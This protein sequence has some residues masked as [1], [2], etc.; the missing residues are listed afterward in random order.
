M[1]CKT[2]DF[3]QQ[4]L[5][6][7]WQKVTGSDHHDI[8]LL[9]AADL[10]SWNGKIAC[11]M[12]DAYCIDVTAGCGSITGSN[13]RSVLLGVYAFFTALGCCFHTP[14]P[15][16]EYLAIRLAVEC[17]VQ[18]TAIASLRHRGICIEGAVSVENVL[19]MIDWL[20]KNG[21]NSYFIQFRE[22]YTFFDHWYSH[23]G[24]T[25]LSPEPYDME[26]CRSFVARA[27]EEIQRRGLIYHKVGHGWTCECL[28]IPST[29]WYP[30]MDDTIPAATR[31]MLAEV[32]GHRK[33]F[34]D[35]PLNTN[36][37]YSSPEARQKFI[38]EVVQYAKEHTDIS[39]IHIW[40]ADGY[41]N[42][43]ECD[44]CRTKTLTDWYVGLLNEIDH[45]LTELRLKTRLVFLIYFE[46][47][48]PPKTERLHNPDRFVLMFA[49]ISRTYSE[50]FYYPEEPVNR[51]DGCPLPAYVQNH[52]E[53]P[54]DVKDNLRFLYRWQEYFSGDA[55]DFDYY[56]MWDIDRE[57]GGLQLA[58]TIYQDCTRLR[59]M[60]LN[61]M[62]S[63][64]RNRASFPTGLCQYVMGQVL[65]DADVPFEQMVSRYFSSAY[66][67]SADLALE[68]VRQLSDRFPARYF[69]NESEVLSREDYALRFRETEKYITE[70]APQLKA[71]A[72]RAKG[73]QFERMWTVLQ[74]SVPI[75]L[76]TARICAEKE[77]GADVERKKALSKELRELVSQT[78]INIQSDLDGCVFCDV[79]CRFLEH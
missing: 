24:S 50:P 25:V 17:T 63:C 48:W 33:F 78:E 31:P 21:F 42:T 53:L 11:E 64:Q 6:A 3:A 39:L 72:Q 76:L 69:R 44:S 60:K 22:G 59:E 4:E 13:E 37:C 55:F 26:K 38:G 65:F 30:V 68:Y 18:K 71:A 7:Y 10:P 62:I 77:A 8:Q 75:H 35:I 2:L 46:L 66:G 32:D 34:G 41:N 74:S 29:G 12:D 40:L 70:M 1:S 27:E 36:L 79:M 61:G 51:N 15:G 57:L 5:S 52:I 54:K 58:Q 43:C 67:P 23:Q 47:L 19:D 20:P 73:S 9:V 56:L 16:G 49:P 45:Q 28:G 14:G